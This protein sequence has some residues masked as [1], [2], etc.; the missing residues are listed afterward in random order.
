MSVK[1]TE[2]KLLE[3]RTN[4]IEES[5]HLEYKAAAALTST[6]QP[7]LSRDISKDVSAMANSDGGTIIYGIA[8][9]SRNKHLPGAIEPI[10]RSSFSKERLEQII[11]STISPK[12]DG[13]VI[14]PVPLQAGID[15]VVFV[16]EIPQARTAHQ[17]TDKLY[18]RRYNFEA[19]A[20]SHYEILD[21][22]ARSQ[23]P[24]IVPDFEIHRETAHFNDGRE[25][26]A[27]RWVLYVTASNSGHRLAQYVHLTVNAPF[28]LITAWPERID[29]IDFSQRRKKSAFQNTAKDR[30]A[31]GPGI[32]RYI[33]ILPQQRERMTGSI[34]LN[35]EAD[36]SDERAIFS[37]ELAADNAPLQSG[38]FKLSAVRTV[39]YRPPHLR[40]ETEAVP[41]GARIP[42]D[43]LAPL[44]SRHKAAEEA[45]KRIPKAEVVRVMGTFRTRFEL[46]LP[47][48]ER[49]RLDAPA[50]GNAK[51]EAKKYIQ[52]HGIEC[53]LL[54]GIRFEFGGLLGKLTPGIPRVSVSKKPG[55]EN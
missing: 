6:P 21:V 20:M 17:A 48:G 15:A 3:Y 1:W 47:S 25:S 16:V 54:D 37:W 30:V 45:E 52:E 19:V 5:L 36:W 34:A 23:H 9:D 53:K 11:N 50:E 28:G 41:R 32:Q 22:M 40:S 49:I 26:S 38:T 18:Y 46:V 43:P 27:S 55:D 12:I 29:D 33:P 51:F 2:Q 39:D 42:E 44:V 8:E 13:L 10:N 35:S 7:K 4:D 14:H 24:V 31:N